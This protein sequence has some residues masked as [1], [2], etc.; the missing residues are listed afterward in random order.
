[1]DSSIKP[2]SP[3]FNARCARVRDANWVCQTINHKFPHFSSTKMQPY[4]ENYLKKNATEIGY[5]GGLNTLSE[6]YN[7]LDDIIFKEGNQK[8][9]DTI[10]SIKK[11]IRGFGAKRIEVS[12]TIGN[13]TIS[14][15]L[16]EAIYLMSKYGR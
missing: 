15:L 12:E 16:N 10:Y 1:M 8:L 11:M 14:G 7:F 9:I 2:Y 6:I 3:N 13:G 5:E 4:I